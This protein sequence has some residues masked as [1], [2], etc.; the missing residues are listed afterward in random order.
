MDEVREN[1]PADPHPV[2]AQCQKYFDLIEGG[3]CIVP[4]DGTERIV[5]AN[6]KAAALYGCEDAEDFLQTFSSDYRNL[7]EEGGYK[8]LSELAGAHPEHFLLSF[9]YRTKERH[10]RKADGVGSLK[11]TPFGKAYVLLLFSA[12]QISSDL[13]AQ[14]FTGVLGMH[15]FFHE[16]LRQAQERLSLPAVRALC[17]VC[18]DLTNFKEYNQLYGIHQGDLCLKKIADTITGCFPG[19]LVGHLTADHFVA[20]LP[21]ADLEAKLELVCNEVNRYINDDGIRLKAGIY[22]PGE[23]DTLEDLR[24]GFDSAK[25]ACDSIKKTGNRSI[26]RYRRAMG[27]T[28]A[29]KAYVLRHFNEALEKHYIKVHFQPVIR[30]LTGKLCGFEALARWEDPVLGMIYPEVFVPILEEAQLINRLDRCVLEQVAGLIRD[31]MDNG[32]PL[33][34]ISINLSADDFEVANP[35]DTIEKIVTHYK[36]PRSVLCFEITERVMIR[37]HLNMSKIICR[38]QQA[39][40][41]VWMD[42]FGSEYSSLNSLHNFHFDVIK[43]DMG[44]FSHFDDRSRQI[45]TSVVAMARMLGVQTL[46]EGVET[47]EQV[48]FL[49]KIGCGRIQGYYYGRPMMYEATFSLIHGTGFRV[50]TPEESHRMDAAESVNVTSDSPT[51]IF[52]FDGTN[53]TLL[54]E[55]DAYK[56]EL[57]TTG[58]QDIDEANANLGDA[59]YPFRGRFQ[60]LLTDALHS[61]SEET[62]TYADNGQYMRVSVRWIAGDERDWVGEAHL[63]NISNNTSIRQAKMLDRTLR[64]IFQ[65]YEGFYLIDRRADDVSILQASHPEVSQQKFPSSI[66]GFFNA[67]A[68]NLVYPD[69]RERFLRFVDPETGASKDEAGSGTARSEVVRIRRTDGTYRW[70]VFEALMIFKSGMNTTLLCEQEDIWER[71]K[72]RDTLLPVFCRSFGISQNEELQPEILA[73]SSLF[74]ELCSSSPYSFFWTDREGRVLGASRKLQEMEGYPDSNT[75]LGKTEK[76]IGCHFNLTKADRLPESVPDNRKQDSGETELTLSGG[77]L[78]EVRFSRTPWYQEKEIAG[79]LRMF[80]GN[81][82]EKNDEALRLGLIDRETGLMSFRGAIEAGLLFADQYRLERLDYVGLLIDVPDFSEV[83]Q[84]NAENGKAALENISVSLRKTLSPG[85]SV[86]RIGLCC[87]LCFCR[88][89]R[90]GKIE[91]KLA[92]VSGSLSLLWRK[93]GIRTLPAL[94]H[95]VVYGTEVMSLDEMLQL[96][97]RRLSNAEKEIYGDS[98]YTEDRIFVR[99]EVLD[100]LQERVIISDPKTYEL[101]YLNAAARRDVG[102]DPDSSLNGCFCYNAL[103]GFDAPCRDCPNLMLRMDRPFSA[104]HMSYRTGKNI[105]VRSFLTKWEKRILKFTVAFNPDE[106]IETMT[107]EHELVYQEMRAN[108]AISCG[109]REA[110]PEKGIERTISCIAENM[111]PERFLIFEERD[112]NTVSATY[113]WTAPGVIPLRAELQSIPQTELRAL[114]SQFISKGLVKVRDLTVFQRD[115]PDF[116]LRIHGVK[117]FISGQLLLQNRREGF[118]L[119]VNPSEESF[120]TGSALYSTLT[121]FIAVMIRNRNSIWDLERQSMID[122]L[123]GA[124]NRR[125]LERRIR[126]WQGDGVLGV[127]SIDLNG[128]KNT[129]DTKGHRAGDILISETARILRE[130]AGSEYVFR[131]GGDEFI[132]VTEDLEERDIR[133]LIRHIRE[134]AENNGISIAVGFASVQGKLTD[135]DTLLTRADFNMYQ[136]KGHSFRRR[137]DDH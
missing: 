39:G 105:L 107:K 15:D 44:F 81:G 25:I 101:V 28:I 122:Q 127:I 76:E 16:A 13:K 54:I 116:S 103:E 21:S 32:L 124:G 137:R 72:D 98:P 1:I 95:A 42:D 17:P 85:W 35:I 47:E 49:R 6:Q 77:R 66:C 82:P 106:F 23:A 104:S 56:R 64:N 86:A 27:E 100:S 43:I 5:F 11:D 75:F 52:H 9:H 14:N 117:S 134:S 59:E 41:Q 57:R 73:E 94:T 113:E 20:L 36:I 92:E 67:F 30:T 48:S 84:D 62:L 8:P 53:I 87:F 131:T 24:H 31:R 2:P 125:A 61:K 91:E 96:L 126:G 55:N 19:A 69:D 51:A 18:L 37:N 132:V 3:I 115:N 108:D 58:T 46:A 99:R 63:Y 102:M 70:T 71:K 26:A 97:T 119:V 4:A 136:D 12:E 89:D 110:D 121:D 45:I 68:E 34:P 10:F 128:L 29:N 79:T 38:F 22:M 33:V 112:D 135:F 60:K 130:C 93:L 120:R 129:N 65:L 90:A 118:T 133:L 109:M 123:T 80:Y 50:E 111:K 74:R 7:V 88:K 40:Y 83:M 78:R 114:Y